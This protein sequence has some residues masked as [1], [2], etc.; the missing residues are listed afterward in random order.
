[1]SDQTFEQLWRRILLY[2]PDCPVPL[3]QEFI[4]TAYS[5]ALARG[6]W[7]G[8]RAE[9]AFSVPDAYS[10][11]TVT[12]TTGSTTVTGSGTTWTSAMVGRQ[13]YL[14]GIGPYYTITA[15]GGVG[16]LT[17]DRVWAGTTA[18]G[19]SYEIALVYLEVPSDFLHFMSVRDT[20][21]N[22][23]LFTNWTQEQ[24]DYVDSQRSTV[25]QPWVLASA[26]FTSSG[27]PRWELWP[28]STTARIY[29][30][31]YVKKPALLSAASDR[32]IF[33]LRGDILR[34]GALA[35]LSMW[36]G[37]SKM[38]NPYFSMEQHALH[39]QMFQQELLRA[40]REDQEIAQTMIQFDQFSALPY[41]PM[42]AAFLQ[43]HGIPW[44]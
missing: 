8:V 23:R 10:D 15:V 26:P 18:A 2:A 9:S 12:M 44:F 42:D 25:G 11:G 17:L 29:P 35:E 20:E 30:F 32:A 28:R 41:P 6:S 24:L 7:T 5:R 1:M 16:S 33:P 14:D 40:E 19:L 21:S 27:R 34:H 22:W 38:Q 31:L 39:E 37:T 4:N 13:L 43:Q 3:A 36:P